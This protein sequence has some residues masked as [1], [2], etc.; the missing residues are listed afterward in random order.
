MIGQGAPGRARRLWIEAHLAQARRAD[1]LLDRKRVVLRDADRS[2]AAERDRTGATWVEADR[3]AQEWWYRAAAVSGASNLSLVSSQCGGRADVVV[4]VDRTAGV[5]RPAA[6]IVALPAVAPQMLAGSS[7]AV[8]AAVHATRRAVEAA[9]RHAVADRAYQLVH[10]EL[11]LTERR[12]RAIERIRIPA[13]EAELA[14]LVLRLDELERQER[15]FGRWAAG[16]REP[17]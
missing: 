12:Q 2:L 3:A 4:S 17:A 16:R 14:A 15:I 1:D 6:A 5:D 10:A 8:R 11:V 9:A 7:P 13:L